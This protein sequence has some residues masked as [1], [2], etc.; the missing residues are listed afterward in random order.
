V[1]RE[2]AVGTP[3]STSPSREKRMS[4]GT[5]G[6]TTAATPQSWVAV[7]DE[8]AGYPPGMTMGG[9]RVSVSASSH[10]QRSFPTSSAPHPSTNVA[11]EVL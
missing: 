7:N 2:V 5:T 6:F 11:A 4:V 9:P 3:Q 10:A 1:R 8:K